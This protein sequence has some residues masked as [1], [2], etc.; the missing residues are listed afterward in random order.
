[1]SGCPAEGSRPAWQ[2]GRPTS[3]ILVDTTAEQV[4]YYIL[5]LHAPKEIARLIYCIFGRIACRSYNPLKQVGAPCTSR[6]LPQRARESDTVW[7]VGTES[8]QP[9]PAVGRHRNSEQI[10]LNF[11]PQLVRDGPTRA[12]ARFV[13]QEL[14]CL[15]LRLGRS[16]R[17]RRRPSRAEGT[18]CWEPLLKSQLDP[19]L[20]RLGRRTW[21]L[22]APRLL[23]ASDL[24]RQPV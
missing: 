1:M 11:E 23:P 10:G 19:P 15:D 2:T 12:I 21:R 5:S 16:R 9:D 14:D 17:D 8:A 4:Y 6:H 18:R 13:E 7:F 3:N 22:G 20:V 24:W